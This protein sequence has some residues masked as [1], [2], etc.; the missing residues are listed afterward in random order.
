MVPIMHKSF[1]NYK[2]K[3]ST[4]INHFH[5]KLLL[6]KDKL[7]TPKARQLAEERPQFMEKFLQTFLTKWN[8]LDEQH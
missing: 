7:H 3:K 1:D 2:K 5:E 4:S 6:L 8:F